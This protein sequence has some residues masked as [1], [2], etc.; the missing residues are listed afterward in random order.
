MQGTIILVIVKVH[1]TTPQNREKQ[2]S[3]G[4][5]HTVEPKTTELKPCGPETNKTRQENIAANNYDARSQITVGNLLD[6]MSTRKQ[7]S[8]LSLQ[9][10]WV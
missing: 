1:R 7:E 9:T 5:K 2:C 10:G 6:S 8:C 4:A 3:T